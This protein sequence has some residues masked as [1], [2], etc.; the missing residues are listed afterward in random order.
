MK[1]ITS[2][3]THNLSYLFGRATRST[4]VCA[5]VYYADLAADRA[6]FYVRNAYNFHVDRGQDR[7]T[8]V[9]D[10]E[11]PAKSTPFNYQVHANQSERMF[12]I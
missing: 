2:D 1:L 3:Q 4:G 10:P 12:Y 7:P 9:L 8:F 6:R 5:P 11:K